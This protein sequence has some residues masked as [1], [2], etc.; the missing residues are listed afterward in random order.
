MARLPVP[1]PALARRQLND[2]QAALGAVRAG[3]LPAFHA[4]VWPAGLNRT[5]ALSLPLTVRVVNCLKA[6][7][8]TQG[9]EPLTAQEL[10]RVPNMGKKSLKV[11]LLCVER[12]LLECSAGAVPAEP[13]LNSVETATRHDLPNQDLRDAGRDSGDKGPEPPESSVWTQIEQTLKPIFA[14]M[15]EVGDARCLS[16]A[17]HPKLIQIASCLGI[18]DDLENIRLGEAASSQPGLAGQMATRLQHILGGMSGRDAHV[19]KR[20]LM[21]RPP[22]TLKD[23]GAELRVTRERIRQI[24]VKLEGKIS[25]ALGEEVRQLAQIFAED[26]GPLL[27][28][29][30]MTRRIAR[31]LA[32]VPEREGILI[33]RH[34]LE[35]MGYALDQGMFVNRGAASEV[36]SVRG[37]VERMADE[38][39]LVNEGQLLE[40]LRIEAPSLAEHWDWLVKRCN[41]HRLHGCVALR[42][43]AKAKVMAALLALGQPATKR[44]IGALCGLSDIRVG[45]ALSNL[46][47]VARADAE[48]WGLREWIDDVYDGIV[49]EIIQRIEEDGGVT[50]TARLL[51]EIPAKFK[52]SPASVDAYM[53][54]PRFELQGGTIRIADPSRLCLRPIDEVIHGRDDKGNPFWTFR[55]EERYFRGFSV[56]NVPPEF[57]K[58]LGCEPDSHMTVYCSGSP[59]E[60]ELSVRWPL[61]STTGGSLGYLAA[62]LKALGLQSGEWARVTIMGPERV[63]LAKHEIVT[64]KVSNNMVDDI[65][66]RMKDRRRAL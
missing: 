36:A 41:L 57:I 37:I 3:R 5:A 51:S 43:S 40:A 6:A 2:I 10:L 19:L 33:Q 20:R 22:A 46:K 29:D 38:T 9:D 25:Q 21:E 27:P 39:G 56:L 26:L 55:V 44:E 49:G 64:D 12:F 54:T 28:Q 23:V 14:V 48:R 65:L 61:A 52:V 30:A 60:Q 31:V 13:A 47:S 8:L 42:N 50:T 58:A 11:L 18:R 17:L 34:L 62:P 16:D 1:S 24:Q 59:G 32:A 66:Q 4:I 7:G 63:E 15:S 53:K 45:G 35:V